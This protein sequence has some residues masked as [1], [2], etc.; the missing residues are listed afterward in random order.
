MIARA[1]C[2]RGRFWRVGCTQPHPAVCAES[3]KILTWRRRAE[4]SLPTE[5]NHKPDGSEAEAEGLWCWQNLAE[6]GYAVSV[7]ALFEK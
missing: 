7:C 3:I 4:R 2:R 5:P 1:F 6:G